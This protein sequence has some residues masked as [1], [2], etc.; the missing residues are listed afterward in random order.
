[1]TSYF[2]K[3]TM[4]TPTSFLYRFNLVK[5]IPIF[6]KLNWFE[7][8]KVARK[9]KVVEHKKGEV[10]CRQDDPPDYFYC[11][12]SGR[13]QVFKNQPN[14]KIQSIDFIHRGM[15]FGVIS[16]L[17]G[18]NHSLNYVAINDSV[19]LKI[20]KEDFQ[21][22]LRTIPHLG[23]ELSQ[24]LSKRLRSQVE[25]RKTVFESTIISIY[26]PVK[27]TGSSTY[28]VNLAMHL[29]KETRKK[30]VLVN[31]HSRPT[32]DT[33]QEASFATQELSP[34]WKKEAIN[35]NEIIGDH[36]KIHEAVIQGDLN[37]DLINVAFNPEDTSSKKLISPFVSALVGDYHYVVVDLPND[38]DEIVFETLAQSDNVHLITSDRKKDLSLIRGVIDRLELKLKEHFR[39]EKIKVIIRA[40]H[41]KIYL[42]FEEINQFLDYPVYT[43]LP[44]IQTSELK[45]EIYGQ[46]LTFLKCNDQSE[47]TKTITRIAREI[48]GVMVG[49]VL[50]GGAALGV[51]HVGVIRVLEEENIPVDI[52]V[53]SSM[54]ALIGSMWA[55]G[56]DSQALEK[57]AREFEKKTNMLKLFDPVIPISGLIGGRLIKRWLRKHLGNKTFYSVKIPF[58]VVAYDLI[59]RE[60]IVIEGGSLVD[61]VRK[62]IAIPG[63]IEPILEGNQVI[64]DGGVLNPLPTNILASR[65]IKKIIAI[66]VLQS[67]EDVSEGFDIEKHKMEELR[68]IPFYKAPLKYLSFRIGCAFNK[69]FNPNIS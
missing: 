61:G 28:A 54:G 53:G 65:G 44:M 9:A 25:G 37:V 64:I 17:T 29:Q 30:V 13:L 19:I 41:A 15:H 31:I 16:V 58:K 67:P 10:F 3:D 32:E 33:L 7:L 4:H 49:L 57:I 14:G 1:M 51:A 40:H 63:V 5:Q 12:I 66:N 35:I 43:A 23:V 39:A 22:I 52:I 8:Q 36:Q 62:S 21:E 11:L 2:L 47:Y 50:G 6:S 18:E 26:S 60:E 46:N 68:R 48:G 59:R 38:M 69:V 34:R 24:I 45:N 42:S 56:N 55:I 27:G 20:P